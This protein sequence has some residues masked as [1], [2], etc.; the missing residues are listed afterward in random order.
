MPTLTVDQENNGIRLDVFLT[1]TLPEVP[2]RVHVKRLID[3]GA[4]LVNQKPVKARYL[5]NTGDVITVEERKFA[6]RES[7]FQPEDIAL[8]VVYEDKDFLIVNKPSGLTVHPGAGTP[9]GT[10]ANALLYQYKQLSSVNADDRPGIVHRLDKETSGLMVVAR[11]DKVHAFLAKQFESRSIWKR[12]IYT[13]VFYFFLRVEIQYRGFHLNCNPG[14][15]HR[16]SIK[17]ISS[18]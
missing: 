3:A 2:S 11:N 5:V 8:D 12:Y 18:L 14:K 4:V 13:K 16:N 10:L 15:G 9:S 1:R 7:T 17:K 6:A